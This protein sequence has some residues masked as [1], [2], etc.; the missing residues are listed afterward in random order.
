MSSFSLSPRTRRGA[1]REQERRRQLSITRLQNELA[2]RTNGIVV[3][4]DYVNN[5]KVTV[6]CQKH[7]HWTTELRRI[8]ETACCCKHCS[9]ERRSIGEGAV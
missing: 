8:Y 7:G 2:R 5:K 3:I 9:E 6:S 4:Q 1:V